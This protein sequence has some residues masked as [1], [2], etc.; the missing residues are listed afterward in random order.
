MLYAEARERLGNRNSRK[1]ANNTYL[2]KRSKRSIGLNG[3]EP[4]SLRLHSTNIL[5]W[6]PDGCVEYY[7][8]GYTTVTTKNR[9]NDYGPMGRITQERYKWYIGQPRLE[10][11]DFTYSLLFSKDGNLIDYE[12][13]YTER[14]S[15]P[16][17]HQYHDP[18]HER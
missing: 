3:D 6:Y 18:R 12:P 4:I 2:V 7:H 11:S 9:L 17:Y 14:G 8:G 13:R 10:W 15:D 1:V 16:I 5:T